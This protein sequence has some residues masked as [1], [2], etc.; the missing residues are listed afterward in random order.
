MSQ[1]EIRDALVSFVDTPFKSEYP[2]IPLVHDNAPFDR[3]E[4]PP[5]WVE[6]E[7]KWAGAKQIG[8]SFVPRT[9]IHGFVYV[10]V[11]VRQGVSARTALQTLDW[12][13]NKLKYSQIGPVHIQA[14]EPGSD[15]P[16]TGWY[17]EQ[18]KFYFYSNPA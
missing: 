10:T 7:I 17:C 18:L 16:P 13:E 4:P 6:F 9:R 2:E 12:F 8:A 5:Q 14:A 11:W 15:T 1:V 3:N